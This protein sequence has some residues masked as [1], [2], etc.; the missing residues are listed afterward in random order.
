MGDRQS[1]VASHY[2]LIVIGGGINGAGIARDAAWRGLKTALIEKGD[3]ASGTTGW[4][5]RL[6]HGGLRYLEYFEFA[7]VRESLREREILLKIA[8]HLVQPLQ[9]TI[10]LYRG[11][12]RSRSLIWAGMM[13]YDLLS[14]DRSLPG[15]RMLGV[16]QFK[17]LFRS[18]NANGIVGAAQY[19]DAQVPRAER[20]CWETVQS[21]RDA[22]ADIFSYAEAIA[23]PLH[24]GAI[25]EIQ[26]R[27]AID[28]EILT[29]PVGAN[30]MVANA[31]GPWVD[32]ICQL[33]KPL[34]TPQLMGGTKG[35]HIIVDPFPGAPPHAFYTEA[36][37]DN[38]P[39]F[40]IP[41]LGRYLIGTTD[42]RYDGSLDAVKAST[43]EIDY[44][45]TETNRV[46]PIAQL[47]RADVQFTYSGIRPLPARP[48]GS[49]SS[50]T[51]S[52]SIYDHTDDGASNLLSLVGGKLT[53]HRG[54]SEE[55]VDAVGRKLGRSLPPSITASTPLP[56]AILPSEPM[57][58][59][60]REKYGDRLPSGTLSHL[61]SIYGKQTASLLALTAEAPELLDPIAPSQ[62]DIKAQVVFA[63]R[64]EMAR[65]M[66]DITLRRTSMGISARYGRD[67]LAGV[68]DVLQ[69]HCGWSRERCD[70]EV[71]AH[72]Q[73][74]QRHC[75]P[76]Y[77]MGD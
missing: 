32:R 20:L 53:T 9:F 57:L 43:A 49:T 11:G 8:P 50:I 63:V 47:T 70:R 69:T 41:W 16:S 17:Q 60:M 7:L 38:R 24:E 58:L 44:L 48:S 40:I 21:A 46:I 18:V 73:Y 62:P 37:A 1:T 71:A 56:G 42:L 14:Y 45:L 59:E 2:D 68:A 33:S 64:A 30:T 22:G 75:V 36:Q 35:S 52:H 74:V 5:T 12:A 31:G 23:M 54:S 3:I 29:I 51:R 4:S 19:F 76:D 34:R 28:G 6:I 26:C 67:V 72:E 65:T 66:V 10:P 39:F 15:H 55:V 13:L 61:L 77:T 25:A 27:D